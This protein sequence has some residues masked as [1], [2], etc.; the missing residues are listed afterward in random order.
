METISILEKERA[1]SRIEFCKGLGCETSASAR[2]LGDRRVSREQSGKD[3]N[4]DELKPALLD[5]DTPLLAR[6][7]LP[8]EVADREAGSTRDSSAENVFHCCLLKVLF[9]TALLP[10]RLA[11]S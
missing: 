10:E 4:R 3:G 6:E 1:P 2:L 8:D 9:S 7:C 5:C 11:V